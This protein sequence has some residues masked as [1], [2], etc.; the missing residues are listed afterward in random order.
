MAEDKQLPPG[1]DKLMAY[2]MGQT[3]ERLGQIESK[4]AELI[5]FRAEV[6]ASAKATSFVMSAV[7]GIVVFALNILLKKFGGI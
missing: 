7:M 6:L 3:N 2:F 1:D 5:A 4:L